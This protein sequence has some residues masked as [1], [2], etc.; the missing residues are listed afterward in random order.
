MGQTL[1]FPV[2]SIYAE[3]HN[4]VICKSAY[5]CIHGYRLTNE[6]AHSNVL[7]SDDVVFNGIFDGH[8]GDLCSN[9]AA[10]HL[11]EKILRNKDV[12]LEEI[13]SACLELD[14]EFIGL[15][16][17]GGST[18]TF[19]II[20]RNQLDGRFLVSVGNIGDSMTMILEKQTSYQTKFITTDHKP[21]LQ[22]EAER[23][24]R[25]GGNINGGRVD[26]LAVSRA[27]G[28]SNFKKNQENQ[29]ENKVIACPDV[30]RF[31]CD[32]GDIVIHICDGITESNFSADQVCQFIIN[33][34]ERYQDLAIVSSLVCLEALA[35]GS[36]DNLSCI[37]TV[38][39]NTSNT[40]S[41][42]ELILGKIDEDNERYLKAYSTFSQL[43]DMNL[44]NTLNKRLEMLNKKEAVENEI[45][46][47]N[48]EN[49]LLEHPLMKIGSDEE[50]ID[51]S[52]RIARIWARLK[53]APSKTSASFS[54]LSDDD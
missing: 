30:D 29:M 16:E 24:I 14:K 23:I 52:E 53:A 43:A 36:R 41:S 21:F 39:G 10:A 42:K 44:E 20:K 8:M 50:I 13:K 34:L 37:I 22:T 48:L 38:L 46:E 18:A 9:Y 25:C 19:S 40:F 12:S 2:R 32:E 6:D 33:N 54:A 26:G 5:S 35:R 15:D 4:N 1:S 11:S 31:L 3:R 51:E 7:S 27:F 47:M 28:N 49:I 45:R 17:E